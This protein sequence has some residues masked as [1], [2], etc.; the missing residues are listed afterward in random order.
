MNG[1]Q[2]W[3]EVKGRVRKRKREKERSV[4]LLIN[5]WTS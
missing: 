1:V 4:E 5:Q 2:T 3:I